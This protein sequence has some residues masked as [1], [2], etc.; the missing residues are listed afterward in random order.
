[1]TRRPPQQD[2][3]LFDQNPH[4]RMSSP[5]FT[6]SNEPRRHH[7]GMLPNINVLPQQQQQHDPRMAYRQP[8]NENVDPFSEYHEMFT[9]KQSMGYTQP[10]PRIPLNQQQPLGPIERNNPPVN[11]IHSRHHQQQQPRP[12]NSND[13]FFTDSNGGDDQDFM[14]NTHPPPQQQHQQ[15]QQQQQQQH[16]QQQHQQQQQQQHQQQQHQ[17]HQQQQRYSNEPVTARTQDNTQNDQQR[18]AIWDELQKTNQKVQ[19][20]NAKK[21]ESANKR[22]EFRKGY[23]NVGGSGVRQAPSYNSQQSSAQSKT[24]PTNNYIEQNIDMIKNKENFFY[25]YPAKKYENLYSKRKDLAGIGDN[26]QLSNRNRLASDPPHH[27]NQTNGENRNA[28]AT[29]NNS[30]HRPSLPITIN[31]NPNDNPNNKMQSG[32]LPASVTI[33]LDSSVKRDGDHIS[34]NIDLRLVDLQNLKQSTDQQQYSQKPDWSGLDPLDR[35][36]RKLEESIDKSLPATNPS[37]NRSSTIPGTSGNFASRSMKNNDFSYSKHNGGYSPPNGYYNYSDKGKEEDSYLAKMQHLHKKNGFKAYTV[38]DYQQ[39]KKNFGFGSGYLGFD[40]DNSSYKEKSDKMNKTKEY[41]QQIEERNK[42][43]LADAPRRT[44]SD[45]RSPTE[46]SKTQRA[47]AYARLA[48]RHVK[49]ANSGISTHSSPSPVTVSDERRRPTDIPLPPKKVKQFRFTQQ[50]TNDDDQFIERL[51]LRHD[52]EKQKVQGILN[53]NKNTKRVFLNDD[54]NNDIERLAQDRAEQR[55]SPQRHPPQQQQQI[56][57]NRKPVRLDKPLLL[58]S[59]NPRYVDSSQQQIR[60]HN[61]Y[62]DDIDQLAVRHNDEKVLMDAIRQELSERPLDENEE[63]IIVE[64]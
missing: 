8:T 25:R 31:L 57:T 28:V 54:I 41:A 14:N 19:E 12:P 62:D 40:F 17:Q 3:S 63:L 48:T 32:K 47:L 5:N 44:L 34:V 27:K 35:H 52:Q 1:M 6:N 59:N 21:R 24:S 45:T 60:I 39:F 10:P 11:Q 49:P 16:Q 61:N 30:Q 33:P 22:N 43:K 55:R 56:P 42:K 15:Q 58:D 53:S 4:E 2:P 20:K 64:Q 50:E 7:N 29:Y 26:E 38:R 9:E 18:Q 51:A 37:L 23:S 36:I 13:M 46:A